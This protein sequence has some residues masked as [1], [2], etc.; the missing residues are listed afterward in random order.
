MGSYDQPRS[1]SGHN[2]FPEPITPRWVPITSQ[3][4]AGP[5]IALQLRPRIFGKRPLSPGKRPSA[6]DEL[7]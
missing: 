1:S 5:P 3:F 2:N 4:S 6:P 7:P